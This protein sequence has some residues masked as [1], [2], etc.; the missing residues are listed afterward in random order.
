DPVEL[1]QVL[2]QYLQPPST[3]TSVLPLPKASAVLVTENSSV[4]RTLAHVIEQVD[5]PPAEVVSEFIKLTRADATKVVDMLKE[6][7]EKGTQTQQ[8][9]TVPG[10][11]PVRPAPPITAP[12]T[13][14]NIEGVDI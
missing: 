4:V 10:V 1:Q 9:G 13:Q 14:I 2:M 12:N 8:P 5:I 6:L 11:R 3:Y 7:F